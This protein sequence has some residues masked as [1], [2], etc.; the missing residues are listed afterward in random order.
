MPSSCSQN[1]PQSFLSS[2][3]IGDS[4]SHMNLGSVVVIKQCLS[5]ANGSGIVSNPTVLPSDQKVKPVHV[6]S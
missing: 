1:I 5:V 2:Q 6:I 3:V 4:S